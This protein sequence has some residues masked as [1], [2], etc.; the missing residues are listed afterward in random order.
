MAWSLTSFAATTG[1][2]RGT[3]GRTLP[4]VECTPTRGEVE[5]AQDRALIE[6]EA[7]GALVRDDDEAADQ[8]PVPDQQGVL[9]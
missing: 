8:A 3:C 6:T 9:E 1:S 2:S 5:P 7:L 4:G